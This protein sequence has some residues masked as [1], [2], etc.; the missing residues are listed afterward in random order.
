MNRRKKKRKYITHTRP[1]TLYNLNGT[2]YGKYLTIRDAAN[3]IN[4]GE[5]TI[6]R[7]LKTAKKLIKRQWLVK[8]T[9]TSI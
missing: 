7:A 5:K 3:A 9:I 2:V 1:L 8:D 6:K 4:C